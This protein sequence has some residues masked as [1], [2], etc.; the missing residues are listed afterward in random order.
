M[1]EA[2]VLAWTTSTLND[3]EV[4]WIMVRDAKRG[5]ELPGGKI[6]EGEAIE[7]AAL[8]EL[9]EET[10]LLGTAKAYD[11]SIVEGGHVVWIEVEEEPVHQSWQSPE[12]RIEEVGWCMQIPHDTAWDSE[13]IEKM[14]GHDWSAATILWS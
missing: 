1:T 3:E 7:E 8:R 14:L 9:F 4:Y 12:H 5:W 6:N 13:E 10:G 2:F 11:S